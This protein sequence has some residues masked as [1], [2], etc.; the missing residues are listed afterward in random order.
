MDI[1]LSS[2]EYN[3]FVQL[4][5]LMRP[6]ALHRLK[7][8]EAE[9]KNTDGN[10]PDGKIAVSPSAKSA[11]GEDVVIVAEGKRTD[12]EYESDRKGEKMTK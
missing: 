6:V 7:S 8:Q 10:Y 1:L 11:K 9:S 5:K 12:E 2:V 4:M 3:T